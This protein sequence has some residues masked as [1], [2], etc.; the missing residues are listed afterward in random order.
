MSDSSGVVW[1]QPVRG[2]ARE[3][4]G[5]VGGQDLAH[6]LGLAGQVLLAVGGADD[7]CGGDDDPGF[8]AI[9]TGEPRARGADDLAALELLGVL[10]EVPDVAGSVLGVVVEG[11][12]DDLAGEAADVVD[13]D[14]GDAGDEL[15]VRGDRDLATARS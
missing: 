10:A 3:G 7:G 5:L 11:V 1:R 4:D 15:G 14:R 8:G 13:D 6:V 12:L 9:D 2:A